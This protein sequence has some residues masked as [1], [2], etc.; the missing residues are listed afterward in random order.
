MEFQLT[1]SVPKEKLIK[2]NVE[3]DKSSYYIY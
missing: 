1:M 2:M 3:N